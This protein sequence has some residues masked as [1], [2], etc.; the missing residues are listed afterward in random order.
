MNITTSTTCLKAGFFSAALGLVAWAAPASATIIASDTFTSPNGTNLRDAGWSQVGATISDLA[1][2]VL[3]QNGT[4][5]IQPAISGTNS[6][7]SVGLP[8][9]QSIS[10]GS[11][12]VGID[13]NVASLTTGVNTTLLYFG[14]NQAQSAPS[15]TNAV[16]T[17]SLS[18]L[19]DGGYQIGISANFTTTTSALTFA[20]TIFDFGTTYRLV[21]EYHFVEGERNDTVTLSIG[22]TV[23]A[24]A[25]WPAT[26]GTE[27][28]PS[29]L[30]IG[31]MTAAR[32]ASLTLD[33][34][35][36]AT[37]YGEAA[38]APV[39][40][41]ATYAAIFGSLTLAGVLVARRR[42]RAAA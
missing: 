10:S 40:E 34:L 20:E 23:V 19:S 38:T 32:P 12:Y 41:P 2:P 15:A 39:P 1:S 6:I 26:T 21:F 42:A 36:I 4:A 22:D 7:E 35:V 31:A 27:R 37:T 8:F 30:G 5:V 9:G 18:P 3:I 17:V 25:A 13:I 28:N 33:N 14:V 29:F 24:T 16:G 11:I